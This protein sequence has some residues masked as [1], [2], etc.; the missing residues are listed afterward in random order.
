MLLKNTQPW[1]HELVRQ[2]SEGDAYGMASAQLTLDVLF[3]VEAWHG[4]PR[5]AAILKRNQ[6]RTGSTLKDHALIGDYDLALWL[7]PCSPALDPTETM[8]VVSLNSGDFDPGDKREHF[9][10]KPF[11]NLDFEKVVQTLISWVDKYGKIAVGS[12]NIRRLKTYEKL[13]KRLLPVGYATSPIL[14]HNV[15][16]GFYITGTKS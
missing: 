7:T 13:T 6:E 3:I 2:L 12:A 5:E 9:N 11:G 4:T 15:D 14:S 16:A 10:K 1:A 8:L